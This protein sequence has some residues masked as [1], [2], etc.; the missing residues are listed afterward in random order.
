MSL[1]DQLR[2]IRKKRGLTQV[3]AAQAAHIAPDTYQ[4]YE[5]GEVQPTLDALNA[6]A[7]FYGVT[8]DDL[9]GC[10]APEAE[11][12]VPYVLVVV[13][14]QNDFVN[15]SLGSGEASAIV[16][17]VVAHIARARADARCLAVIATRDT[18]DSD[19]LATQEG[20]L[21]P[22]PHCLRD[23]FGWQLCGE[24]AQ[25]LTGCEKARL[26]DK[27]SFGSLELSQYVP[28]GTERIELIGLCTDVCVI[29]N[30][31]LLKAQFPEVQVAVLA[32]CCAG[33]TT[34]AHKTAL[35]AMRSLQI[36]VE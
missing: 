8:L 23:T 36:A 3:Q 4:R 6:L 33:S 12:A 20:R 17:P 31:V 30:A 2:A 29:S 5:Q 22:V 13:D 16:A 21:L 34:A 35:E 32:Q 24:V 10:A 7:N 26:L 19:Y 9:A 18:H 11:P 27:P 14:M 28:A 25:A 15:G 1:T